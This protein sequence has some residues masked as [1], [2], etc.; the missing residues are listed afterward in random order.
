MPQIVVETLIRA[1]IQIVFDAARDARLHTETT[2]WTREQ[3]VAGRSSGLFELHD[4]VT[5]QATHFWIRQKLSARIVEMNPPQM[6]ADEMLA[7]A[8]KKLRHEHHFQ[9]VGPATKMTDVLFWTAPLGVLG[10]LADRAFLVRYM[11]RF[12]ERRNRALKVFL[13]TSTRL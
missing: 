9:S 12:L 8:F 6:F 10:K 13:E 11:T 1:P 4:E 7:G 2:G 3:I 5:F